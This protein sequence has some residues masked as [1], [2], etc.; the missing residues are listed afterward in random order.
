MYYQDVNLSLLYT[1]NELI[2]SIPSTEKLYTY[3]KRRLFK[4]KRLYNSCFAAKPAMGC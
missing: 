3:L 2:C 4:N 1:D